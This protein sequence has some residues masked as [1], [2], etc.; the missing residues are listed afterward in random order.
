MSIRPLSRSASLL[1]LT[2][3]L[4]VP[5]ASAALAE[6]TVPMLPAIDVV[7][8]ST[9]ADLDP[10]SPTNPM[11][12]TR[13]STSHT[14]TIGRKE[15]ED[16]RPRDV[17]DLV[18]KA[19]GVIATQSSRKGWSGLSIR[20][21]SNFVWIV[22]GAYLQPTMAGRIMR[23]IPVNIIEE[24]TVVRGASA[25]TLAPMVGS[26]SP[27]GAPVDG[28]VVVRTR[29]PAGREA[30]SRV[31]G[32]MNGGLQASQ[33][34]GN[35]FE[36]DG[37]KGYVAGAASHSSTDGPAESLDNGAAYNAGS[38]MTA[39][40][41][42]AGWAKDRWSIDLTAYHDI[43]RF[44]IPNA[45]SHGTGQGSWYMEPAQTFMVI[46]N[47]TMKWNDTNTTLLNLSRVE[48]RQ[49]LWTANT[50]A[51][52]YTSA[53][54]PNYSTHVNL[55]HNID[56]DTWRLSVGG[57]F[58]N[59]NAP[60]GQQYYEGIQREENTYGGFAQIEKR[61]FDDKLTIDA[62]VRLDQVDV[63]HGLDYY[64]GGAQPFGGVNSPLKTTNV[65]LPLAKFYEL[66]ASWRVTDD[67]KL[68]GRFGGSRQGTNGVAP[69]PGVTLADDS[70]LKIEVGIEGRINRWF[71]PAINFFHR[72]VE[73]EKT[74]YGYTY[75]ATNNTT[76]TCKTGT[77]PTA[78]AL[79]PKSTSALTPCYDQ[80]NT[81]REGIE[82]TATGELW[83]GGSYK[84]NF[85][86]F[87]ML[88][89]TSAITPRNM[90]SLSLQQKWNDWLLT[91][92]VKYVAGY[93]GSA[94]DTTA[95]L[96][97][98][99]RFDAGIGREFKWADTSMRATLYGRN[100]TDRRYET[101]NGVQDVGRVVG[102][103]VLAKF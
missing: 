19:G 63:L 101:S 32:E 82:L 35:T 96:G 46:A 40:L 91:G 9:R 36:R 92:S 2:V 98:Y 15:I 71:N 72:A 30:E 14:E 77:I 55:R 49:T 94:S 4:A 16:L 73:N 28:F 42:K 61:F 50:A 75:L 86:Q 3:A 43:G 17:F 33:W 47:G 24:V 74:L 8:T 51:G 76:Q 7:G 57:D 59:W 85:T 6:D 39:G 10:E 68:T 89:N 69:R 29:K 67:W 21:D 52:P 38:Q 102:L 37:G 1:T 48:A 31:A 65:T 44:E 88:Q 56:I 18:N 80:A 41:A 27:G 84:A 60:N 11:R 64:T 97:G 100:L 95:Y 22:D 78:G 26:A 12:L 25:L 90:G 20:G 45:N 62:A 5:S 66:G 53:F 34:A 103:E 23:N 99:A 70:Q 79:S 58:R 93:K 87:T 81:T 83:N 13:S 54:N